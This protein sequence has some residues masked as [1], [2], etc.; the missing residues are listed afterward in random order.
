MCVSIK[1]GTLSV[2]SE[3]ELSMTHA[4]CKYDTRVRILVV[5]A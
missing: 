2:I 5:C 4:G 1:G 3:E